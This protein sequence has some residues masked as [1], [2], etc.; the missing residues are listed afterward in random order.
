MTDEQEFEVVDV[1]EAGID[2]EAPEE[3]RYPEAWDIGTE[4]W[5]AFIARTRKPTR[6]I[7]GVRDVR[8]TKHGE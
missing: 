6:I 1:S 8:V 7:D 3:P 2:A 5:D 4:T